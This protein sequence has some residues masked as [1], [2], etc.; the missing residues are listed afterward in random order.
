ML[1]VFTRPCTYHLVHHFFLYARLNKVEKMS[2]LS[3]QML[4]TFPLYVWFLI[5]MNVVGVAFI[6]GCKTCNSRQARE[7]RLIA[8]Q[9]Q[10]LAK[11]GLTKPPN[12]KE[13]FM[14]VSR[15][16]MQTY[17]SAVQEKDKL[18]LE[19]KLCRSQVDADEEYFAKRVERLLLEKEVA[20]T[21][22]PSKYAKLRL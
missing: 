4:G 11:L 16:V 8:V 10:I 1:I 6:T 13:I 14:N 7:K 2:L 15:E 22:V 17:K 5:W 12:G 19:S 18:L 3:S 21:V 9:G 20:R